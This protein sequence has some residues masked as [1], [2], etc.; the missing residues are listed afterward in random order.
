MDALML[1]L[2][3]WINLNTDYDTNINLPNI[4]VTEQANICQQ[5][6]IKDA[7]TCQTTRLKGFYDR[8]LT[9]YL[10]PGFN[11]ADK[12][13]QSR[14][15]H[16]LV[17][18]I[19]WHNGRDEGECWGSLEAEAYQLQDTWRGEHDVAQRADAFKLIMLEAACEA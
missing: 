10:H 5:Y 7:G 6:G 3:D 19:Q 14:L 11:P 18:Y 2:V 15:V 1:A 4:V 8:E 16:E 17:H 13:D 12:N 9:I